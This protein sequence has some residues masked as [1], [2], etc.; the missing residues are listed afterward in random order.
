MSKKFRVV[1]P[2]AS[3]RS[4]DVEVGISGRYEVYYSIG[5]R[6]M[7][8]GRERLYKGESPIGYEILPPRK[9]CWKPPHTDEKISRADR[10]RILADLRAAFTALGERVVLP[11]MK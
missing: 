5:D 1:S 2:G 4:V 9:W 8:F 11:S 7:I 10:T 6:V 3:A